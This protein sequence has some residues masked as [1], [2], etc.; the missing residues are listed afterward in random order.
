VT[1]TPQ[2]G[3]PVAKP[4][5][6]IS[7]ARWIHSPLPYVLPTVLYLL[8]LAIYPLLYSLYLSF[9]DY[10]AQ[11]NTFVFAGL[12]NYRELLTDPIFRAS[13]A[14]TL[15]FTVVVTLCEV[16]LGLA[17]ALFFER[18]FIG[19]ALMRTALIIPMLSTPMVVGL[20]WRFLLN[21]DWGVINWLFGFVG[22][23]PINWVGQSPWSLISLMLVDI[24]QWTPFAFLMLYAGLQALPHEPFEAAKVD[25]ANAWQ[26][27]RY[28]TLPLLRPLIAILLIFRSVDAFRS[29]DT[30]FTLTYGGPGTNSYLLSF[31]AYLVGFSF[32]RMGYASAIAYVMVIFVIIA[33]TLMVRLLHRMGGNEG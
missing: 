31:Y 28:I 25:G 6:K 29:F 26:R 5:P 13:F 18:D 32:L 9:Q 15:V 14:H 23:G 33:T 8:A 3:K 7:W 12:A 1:S 20:M 27:L 10:T 19:K 4:S 16:F 11:T 24:W 22:I 17:L 30:V 2:A 21:A